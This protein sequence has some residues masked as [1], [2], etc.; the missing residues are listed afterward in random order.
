MSNRSEINRN[1]AKYS[2]APKTRAGKQRSSQNAL[3][4]GLTAQTVVM[5]NE[6]LE[7]YQSHK[8]SGSAQE[9]VGRAGFADFG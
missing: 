1:N 6:S 2:T 7:A 3:R 4:H 8:K 5:P 9:S